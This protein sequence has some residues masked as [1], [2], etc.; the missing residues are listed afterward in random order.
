LEASVNQVSI[1]NVM[2]LGTMEGTAT[3]MATDMLQPIEF[4]QPIEA[5]QPLHAARSSFSLLSKDEETA[6]S[7]QLS[8][9]GSSKENA[10]RDLN[11]D[12][13]FGGR[14]TFSASFRDA[15]TKSLRIDDGMAE[16]G[17]YLTWEPAG[18]GSMIL[19]WSEMHVANAMAFFRPHS[20]KP[21]PKFKFKQNGG[22]TELI[23]NLRGGT[24]S[25]GMQRYYEGWT[26]FF[27][28]A[29]EFKSD[30]VV[31]DSKD[32]PISV[33]FLDSTNTI[34]EFPKNKFCNSSSL[35]AIAVVSASNTK[36]TGVNKMSKDY[37]TGTGNRE[38][39]AL[40][41]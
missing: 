21:V 25:K 19:T 10:G 39:A 2:V 5:I 11:M 38:G 30:L 13:S 36:F 32:S 24:G 20:S 3:A 37:F 1:L 29:R 28:L 34:F 23:R 7:S 8:L 18:E 35:Q 4:L 15:S 26:Q 33:F 14:S 17:C 22:R 6:G 31:W 40:L 12:A 27:K 9:H 41:F 16:V